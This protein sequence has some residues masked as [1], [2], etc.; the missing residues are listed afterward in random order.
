MSD[1]NFSPDFKELDTADVYHSTIFSDDECDGLGSWGDPN[2]DFQIGTGGLKDIVL[3]YPSPHRIRRNF[4]L[5]FPP[6]FPLPP[7]VTPDPTKMFNTTFT[8]EVV[9]SVVN[10]F[11]GDYKNFQAALEGGPHPGPHLILGGDMGGTC[12][13]G[14]GPPECVIGPRW[15]PNGEQDRKLLCG[16]ID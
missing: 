4:T 16:F 8:S 5:Y 1:F 14:T 12:P 13:F 15:S 11:T 6:G 7:G 2:N 3:A 10:S 9:D